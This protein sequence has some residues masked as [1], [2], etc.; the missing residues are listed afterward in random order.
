[1]G[2]RG[3][4]RWEKYVGGGERRL[5]AGQFV[6]SVAVDGG[7]VCGGLDDGRIDVWRRSTLEQERTLTWHGGAVRALLFVG[8]RLVSGSYDSSVRVWDFG[9]GR[10]EIVLEGHTD[11]VM[12]LAVG[13]TSTVPPAHIASQ[14][15]H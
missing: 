1:M 11:S 5:A 6:C 3:G 4:V 7:R 8:G 2:R 13:D 10:C 9:E 12:S 14:L 15:A